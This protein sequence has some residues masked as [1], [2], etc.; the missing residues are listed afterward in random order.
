MVVALAL[1]FAVGFAGAQTRDQ[2]AVSLRD[3]VMETAMQCFA[4]EGVYPPSLAYME[5][6]YGLTVNHDSYVVTYESFAP[7]VMPSVAVTVR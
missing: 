1:W 7:N 5:E 6:H 3:S 2:G 4:I